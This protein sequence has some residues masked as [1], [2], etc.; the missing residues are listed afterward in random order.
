MKVRQT[1]KPDEDAEFARLMREGLTPEE[2]RDFERYIGKR[3]R[4]I[5]K[6][7]HPND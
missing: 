1:P 7:R 6:E 2:R 3:A 4:E 5:V